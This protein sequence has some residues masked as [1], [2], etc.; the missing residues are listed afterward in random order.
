[1]SCEDITNVLGLE[2]MERKKEVFASNEQEKIILDLIES[3]TTEFSSNL[4]I[5]SGLDAKFSIRL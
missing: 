4:L 5:E 2:H 3:S 1:M